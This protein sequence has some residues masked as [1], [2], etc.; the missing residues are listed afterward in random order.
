MKKIVIGIMLIMTC[1]LLTGCG[2]Q[3]N[4]IEERNIVGGWDIDV[5]IKQL[6]IPD[7]IKDVFDRA[8]S[9]YDKMT[10][11]P[12]SL[13]GKQIVSG[14]NYMFL[15]KGEDSKTTKWVLVTIYLDPSNNAEIKNVKYLNLNKYVNVDS[16]YNYTQTI[17]GWSVY[18]DIVTNIDTNIEEIFNKATADNEKYYYVP[19]AL[20]GEQ[21]VAG[22]NYAVL[23]LGQSL[24]NPDIYSINILTIYSKLD[25]TAELTSSSYIPLGQYSN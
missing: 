4:V 11:T 21:I 25:G 15:C 5:P 6:V 2:K 7:N 23:A 17:G 18:K 8:T 20:L 12:I 19:I 24:E 13:I 3:D 22:T 1:L 9:N 10:L 14:T 16:E